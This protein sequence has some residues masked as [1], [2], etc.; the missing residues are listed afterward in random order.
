MT[1]PAKEFNLVDEPW[2][3]VLTPSGTA[4]VSLREV[5][6]RGAQI[7]GLAGES[8]TQDVAILR[9]LLAIAHRAAEGPNSFTEW[10]EN[11][12]NRTN[13]L[14]AVDEYLTRHRERFDL[15]H[16]SAPFY[17][18]VDLHTSKKA[19]SPVSK[20]VGDIEA[21]DAIFVHR[22][23]AGL[24]GLPWAEAARWLVHLQAFDY[25][26]IKSGAVGD[27]RVKGGRGYP[28]G[29]G[30]GGQLG[31]V[32]L[33]G[34]NLLE[35][36]LLN[37]V[38]PDS[39]TRI[40][41][42]TDLPPWERPPL[43]ASE[44]L[45]M[46]N[47]PR[48]VIGAYTWQA[49]RVRLAGDATQCTS[50]LICNGD[51]LTPQNR[52]P[53]EPMTVWRYS[54]PQTKKLGY[55]TYMPRKLSAEKAFWRG[56]SAALPQRPLDGAKEGTSGGRPPG[57]IENFQVLR[58]NYI[59]DWQGAVPLQVTGLEYGPQDAIVV[60][61]LH[62]QLDLPLAAF[63]ETAEQVA[64]LVDESL[65][66]ADAVGMIIGRLAQNLYQAAGGDKETSDKPRD[67]ARARFFAEMGREFHK[68]LPTI[69]GEDED[70]SVQWVATVRRTALTIRDELVA[71]VGTQAYKGRQVG[72]NYVDVGLA[73]A[74]FGAALK[75]LVQVEQ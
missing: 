40:T 30:W 29:T 14:V 65:N 44:E 71:D 9:L 49:R 70:E 61:L 5:F 67:A 35:T 13:L 24:T 60:G 47:G 56:L 75:K 31:V 17:Q 42:V 62:D 32:N 59:L 4:E 7:T 25:S 48:G 20:L 16:P 73:L 2:I 38:V 11:W 36:I 12:N 15:R 51:K 10:G 53:I 55:P 33:V 23:E 57:I 64:S 8:P 45:E 58:N 28:I 3:R 68:W 43:T 41:S 6:A 46:A 74:W 1:S 37:M 52:M 26:G 34:G 54:E 72:D 39:A 69:T 22:A 66:L 63:G 50:V 19:M 21:A 27:P 18:V